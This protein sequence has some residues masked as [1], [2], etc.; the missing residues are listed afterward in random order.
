M[1]SLHGA[2][3]FLLFFFAIVIFVGRLADVRPYQEMV[4]GL[5]VGTAVAGD[6]MVARGSVIGPAREA[7]VAGRGTADFLTGGA[8]VADLAETSDQITL[9]LDPSLS[10]TT[11][12]AALVGLT[13]TRL[14]G[15]ERTV[16]RGGDVVT[17]FARVG[18][19][20]S[21]LAVTISALPPQQLYDD[22]LRTAVRVLLGG[23]GMLAA[24]YLLPVVIRLLN[25][26]AV[27]IRR[28]RASRRRRQQLRERGECPACQ[29]SA[30]RG[31]I[32]CVECGRPLERGPQLQQIREALQGLREGSG[33]LVSGVNGN[34]VSLR[35]RRKEGM[36]LEIRSA[37]I[38]VAD[39]RAVRHVLSRVG[40][41][42]RRDAG[43][44]WIVN[45]EEAVGRAA[46]A[47]HGIFREVYRL[48]PDYDV[49]TRRLP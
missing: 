18:P 42:V 35:F 4:R 36:K 28:G 49:E 32:A 22:R 31:F 34:L 37:E 13:S 25:R 15:K 44:V 17:V 19:G 7:V 2:L 5:D 16:V 40:A 39:T 27:E 9:E 6:Q 38:S 26:F 3:P 29:P 30:A 33:L 12:G 8:T 14:A 45:F 41:P 11:K 47:A 1:R 43:P 24:F 48:D 10:F 20:E 46:A 21:L 23:L